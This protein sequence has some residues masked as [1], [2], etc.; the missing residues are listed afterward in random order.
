MRLTPWISGSRRNS[1]IRMAKGYRR[2]RTSLGTRGQGHGVR[3]HTGGTEGHQGDMEGT[4][5]TLRGQGV[6]ELGWVREV[7]KCLELF[8]SWIWE[9]DGECGMGN[10]G[11]GMQDE[12]CK[13]GK[14]GWGL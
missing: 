14:V 10:V 12:E 9:W 8:S 11:W 5:D 2:R 13:M 3:G 6:E 1:Q 4:G 7:P